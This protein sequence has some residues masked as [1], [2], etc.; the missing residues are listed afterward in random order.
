MT[1]KQTSQ[2]PYV[3]FHNVRPRLQRKETRTCYK[4]AGLLSTEE[5]LSHYGPL[6]K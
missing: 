2:K 5:L 6:T 4:D 1:P 3:H